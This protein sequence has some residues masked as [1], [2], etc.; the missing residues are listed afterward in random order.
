MVFIVVRRRTNRSKCGRL[1][2]NVILYEINLIGI[3]VAPSLGYYNG[4]F[5]KAMHAQFYYNYCN[6][7]FH[8]IKNNYHHKHENQIIYLTIGGMSHRK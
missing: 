7:L 6:A 8:K 2:G 1:N 5:S 4:I 3:E